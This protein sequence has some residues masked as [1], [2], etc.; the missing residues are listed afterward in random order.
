MLETVR[1]GLIGTLRLGLGGLIVALIGLEVAQVFLRY[2]LA[3]GVSWGREVSTLVMFAIAWLGA[4]LLWLERRHLAVDLLPAAV[5]GSR[6]WAIALDLLV[7]GAGLA[8]LSLTQQAMAAF[9]FI[10][11]PSLGTSASVKFWPMALGTVLL[12]VAGGLNLLQRSR[13]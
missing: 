2:F 7:I 3:S 8:L 4:P 9:A 11:L 6:A 12:I 1:K 5:G 13:P 10:E